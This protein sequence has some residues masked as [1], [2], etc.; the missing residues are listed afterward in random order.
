MAAEVSVTTQEAG[1]V[2]VAQGSRF[3]GYALYVKDSK[4]KFA[5]NFVGEFDQIV[6]STEPIP[7]GQVVLSASFAREGD[8]LPAEGTLTLHVGDRT[9]G[10]GRIKTQVGKF[11]IGGEGL[12]V[13]LDGGEAVTDDYPGEAPWAFTGGTIKRV[14]IDVSGEPFVD[15][16][17][18]AQMA[19]ARD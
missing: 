19:Y 15:L 5:Y 11:A 3:G 9:V 13:G 4:L 17:K 12:N 10:E 2:L 7:T 18:E 14:I 6:E 8:A 1:G 16:A